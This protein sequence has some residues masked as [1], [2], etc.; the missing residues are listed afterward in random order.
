MINN[1]YK[2]LWC[3]EGFSLING[4]CQRNICI[5]QGQ[6]GV[7]QQVF[8]GYVLVG[9]NKFLKMPAN[10]LAVSQGTSNCIQCSNFT[11]NVSMAAGQQ[12]SY[13]CAYYDANCIQYN[14]N[15]SCI[16]CANQDA[17]DGYILKNRF[18]YKKA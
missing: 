7:C 9:T 2:C 13:V 5:L 17:N 12:G 18:C 4:V 14:S 11:R 3:Q 1:T 10:C 8:I 6:D 15:G 16:Q